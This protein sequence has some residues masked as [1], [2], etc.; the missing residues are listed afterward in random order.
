MSESAHFVTV[1]SCEE[2]QYIDVDPTKLLD[3]SHQLIL[4]TEVGGRDAFRVYFVKGKMRLQASS[5]VGVIPLN[6][7]VV[8]KVKPRVPIANLTRMVL[9]TG[10]PTVALEA[11]RDYR[12]HGQATDWAMD[13]YADALI[14][15][16]DSVLDQGLYRK[17]LRRDAEGSSPS[18]KID[19]N[20]TAARFAGRCTPYKAAYHWYERSADIP[21]NQCLKAAML[22]I[23]RHLTRDLS[24]PVSGYRAKLNRLSGQLAA[25]NDVEED[26]E[27]RVLDD[28]E[29]VGLRALPDSRYYY[30]PA[31][32]VALLILREQGVALELGGDDVRLGS[33]LIEMN[34]LFES[35]VRIVLRQ[36]A[37]ARGW[38]VEVLDGN[39]DGYVP[40]YDVPSD[41]PAPLG[42]AMSALAATEAADAKPDIVFR[43]PDGFFP[44][45]AE[46]KNTTHGR[47]ARADVLPERSEVN[48]AVTY[49]QR[50]RL[51][52][53]LLIHPW[54]NGTKG[55]VYAGR[56]EAVDVFDYRFDLS[57]SDLDAVIGNM[58]DVVEALMRPQR[59]PRTWLH[60]DVR[61]I[62]KRD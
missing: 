19:F 53:T 30:R 56:L 49:A 25:F 27:Y 40:L 11:F 17:Y 47:T 38:S 34:E 3:E 16:V 26:Q 60:D 48:Q 10:H 21:V 44:L 24:R 54:V 31:L 14:R 28:P 2:H 59:D 18:G 50:Y 22:R 6:D 52:K 32:D 51:D 12:G 58:A 55:L 8:L 43:S 29:V 15:N 5:L 39:K 7:N 45:V 23:H 36:Q 37:R 41:P 35:F 13:L 33:I 62:H 20:R 1:Y 4:N 9:D 42:T 46:V 57:S 61:L